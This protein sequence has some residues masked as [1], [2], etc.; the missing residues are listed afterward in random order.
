MKTLNRRRADFWATFLEWAAFVNRRRV[1]QA[2]P[3]CSACR[4]MRSLGFRLNSF[5][6]MD[7]RG[8]VWLQG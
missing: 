3:A 7:S 5:P 6:K 4:R 8:V 2:E 1:K